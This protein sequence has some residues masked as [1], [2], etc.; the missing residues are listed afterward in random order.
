MSVA[1]LEKLKRTL[2]KSNLATC[3]K[4]SIPELKMPLGQVTNAGRG[5]YAQWDSTYESFSPFV[6]PRSTRYGLPVS[7]QAFL[8][9]LD[10]K[11][12]K[13]L[14][15]ELSSLFTHLEPT[16]MSSKAEASYDIPGMS[17]QEYFCYICFPINTT[18][19]DAGV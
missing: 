9:Q 14:R 18:M 4:F 5:D 1:S 13:R 12:V 11:R 19:L 7:Y 15:E 17:Q 16:A 3:C 2:A 8:L 10:R 6:V